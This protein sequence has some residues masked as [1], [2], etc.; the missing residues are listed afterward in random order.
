MAKTKEEGEQAAKQEAPIPPPEITE[1]ETQEQADAL[2]K[3]KPV[4][5]D[6]VSRAYVSQDKQV[7]WAQDETTAREY[8]SR[9]GLKLFEVIL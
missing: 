2:A 1:V 3:S 9:R 6:G 7:W 5:P 4:R 8:V